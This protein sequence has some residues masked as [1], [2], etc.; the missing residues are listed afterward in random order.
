MAAAQLFTFLG[1]I[2]RE[3]IEAMREHIVHRMP[4]FSSV[5]QP[6]NGARTQEDFVDRLVR[7][8]LTVSTT[9]RPWSAKGWAETAYG[10][11][12]SWPLE[13]EGERDA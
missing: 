8:M 12:A 5:V 2:R 11:P 13:H 4:R 10:S 9:R 6:R 7:A 1:A 3:K